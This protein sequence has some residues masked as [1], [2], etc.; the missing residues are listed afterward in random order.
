MKK[1]LFTIML[2][3]AIPALRA[4][5]FVDNITIGIGVEQWKMPDVWDEQLIKI[6]TANKQIII[7]GYQHHE[8]MKNMLA[9]NLKVGYQFAEDWLFVEIDMHIAVNL[10]CRAFP[11]FGANI[12]I[13]DNLKL[14]PVIGWDFKQ[15]LAASLRLQWKDG[16]A[17]AGL[18]GKQAAITIG[19]RGFI[20]QQ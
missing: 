20:T 10:Y 2:L 7:T 11:S 15:T 8:D 19:L 12:P 18:M 4:Q 3:T 6:D 14:S 1:L 17:Q 9:G 16:F 5:T 13:A